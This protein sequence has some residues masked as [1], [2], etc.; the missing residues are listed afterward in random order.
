MN[1]HCVK[2]FSLFILLGLLTFESFAQSGGLEKTKA[3]VLQDECALWKMGEDGNLVNTKET[4]SVGS[5]V[6]VMAAPDLSVKSVTAS[7]ISNRVTQSGQFVKVTYIDDEFYIL[8]GRIGVGME[9]AV[10]TVPSAAVYR[11]RNLADITGAC[12]YRGKVLAVGKTYDI[13]GGLGLTAVAYFDTESRMVRRGYIRKDRIS[14]NRDDITAIEMLT[15]ANNTNDLSKKRQLVSAVKDLNVSGNVLEM[16]GEAEMRVRRA[17]DLSLS[18]E[19][20]VRT[21]AYYYDKEN[22]YIYIRDIPSTSGNILG[23]LAYEEDFTVIRRTARSQYLY[24]V[25][26]YW[27]YG[28]SADNIDG[29]IFGGLLTPRPIE[30]DEEELGFE[31]E[32]G[33]ESGGGEEGSTETSSPAPASEASAE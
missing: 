18:G 2:K 28:V 24:G 4:L 33:E 31:G 15:I 8:D 22:D 13:A 9:S 16:I 12:L 6:F 11:T 29:W 30:E 25:S 17:S 1:R 23:S 21:Q 20:D 32:E 3:I 26:D 14:A 27:Y 7:W 5:E 19:V 10:I